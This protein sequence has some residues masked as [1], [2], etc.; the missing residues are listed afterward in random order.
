VSD[1]QRFLA[2]VTS[3]VTWTISI[4]FTALSGSWQVDDVY[5]D[6]CASKLG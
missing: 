2:N 4:R 1:V 6:P 5:L 3:V